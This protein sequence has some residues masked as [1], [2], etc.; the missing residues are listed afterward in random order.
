MVSDR[1]PDE[2]RTKTPPKYIPSFARLKPPKPANGSLLERVQPIISV[3]FESVPSA[4][5]ASRIPE[6]L[7]L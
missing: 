1:F 4:I 3:V 2:S 5:K 6:I 7:S